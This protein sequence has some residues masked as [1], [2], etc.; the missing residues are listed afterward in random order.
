MGLLFLSQRLVN[1]PARRPVMLDQLVPSNLLDTDERDFSSLIAVAM[2]V[3]TANNF[4]A[5]VEEEECVAE[6]IL[7]EGGFFV[8]ED[9]NNNG[10]IGL[11]RSLTID[12]NHRGTRDLAG[13]QVAT[14]NNLTIL[15]TRRFRFRLRLGKF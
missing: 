5:E 8:A 1:I 6:T 15:V 10:E 7:D 3:S 2:A 12:L 11:R 13:V 14:N 4:E 9:N